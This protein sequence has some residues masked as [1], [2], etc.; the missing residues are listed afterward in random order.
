VVIFSCQKS[1]SPKKTSHTKDQINS[2]KNDDD[3]ATEC[4]Q[5]G[6]PYIEV[7]DQQNIQFGKKNGKVV[8]IIYYNTET[9]FIVEVR[10]TVGWS[11]VL[12]N[13]KPQWSGD[14][15]APGQWEIFSRPLDIDWKACDPVNFDLKVVG[16]GVS[17]NFEV[18]YNLIGICD[19]DC[20]PKFYGQPISCGPDREAI[21]TFIPSDDY[22]NISIQGNLLNFKGEDASIEVIGADLK[23]TQWDLDAGDLRHILIAGD[24]QACIPIKIKIK[25]HSTSFSKIITSEFVVKTEDGT[26]LAPAI[27]GL[28]C[29]KN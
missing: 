1:E 14:P 12:I 17:A 2:L 6:G 27:E 23:S 15:V 11:N 21:Y 4:I 19:G 18:K 8:D 13:G 25:W 7:A 22:K 16:D 3:C 26:E 10:S 29:P 28:E 24:I 5:I 20:K 9:D